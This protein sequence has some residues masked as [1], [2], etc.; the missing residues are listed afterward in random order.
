MESHIERSAPCDAAD[1]DC[2]RGGSQVMNR[3][4]E[5]VL[6]HDSV[7]NSTID[8][9]AETTADGAD[10]IR[11]GAAHRGRALQIVETPK[12]IAIDTGI[13]SAQVEQNRFPDVARL[14]LRDDGGHAAFRIQWSLTDARGHVRRCRVQ[15]STIERRHD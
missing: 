6:T 14:A 1:R 4:R 13:V 11:S 3:E 8:A 2:N 9:E 5:A 10:N 15:S 7:D 12:S